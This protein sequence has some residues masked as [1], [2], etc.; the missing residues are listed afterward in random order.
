MF[1]DEFE[2]LEDFSTHTYSAQPTRISCPTYS[3]STFEQLCKL[4]T[5][6]DRVICA[7]YSEGTSAKSAEELWE[8]AR[9]LHRQLKSWRN[10][11]PEHLKVQL[12]D[13]SNSTILPH[14][15]SLA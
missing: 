12:N 8:T 1:L 6:M 7:L 5:I 13:A 14:T 4:S 11:L 3:V 10:G 9:S 2:E 15:L